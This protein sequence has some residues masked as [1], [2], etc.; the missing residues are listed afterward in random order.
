MPPN[1][2]KRGKKNVTRGNVINEL[3]SS[4][5]PPVE[6]KAL[7]QVG[8]PHLF[9]RYVVGWEINSQY[10]AGCPTVV[11]HVYILL[12]ERKCHR[13]GIRDQGFS[14]VKYCHVIE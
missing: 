5:L 9:S 8:W 12:N 1:V 6:N 13:I 14:V 11:G 3:V 2:K 10:C 7:V 4:P